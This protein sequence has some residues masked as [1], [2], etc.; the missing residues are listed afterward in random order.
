MRIV[1][2]TGD[3]IACE[4]DDTPAIFFNFRDQRG[5]HRGEM[6]V[7]FLRPVPLTQRL[8]QAFGQCREA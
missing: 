4:A 5:I 2:P 3:R 7:Q 6:F 8:A 1:E